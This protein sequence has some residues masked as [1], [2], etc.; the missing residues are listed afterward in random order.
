[1]EQGLCTTR[2]PQTTWVKDVLMRKKQLNVEH[3][4]Q[5]RSSLPWPYFRVT[6]E[7]LENVV[8]LVPFQDIFIQLFQAEM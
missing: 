6:G 3:K 5:T 8:I 1:M 2:N 4:V 7:L